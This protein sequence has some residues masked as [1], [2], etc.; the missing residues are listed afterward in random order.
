[1]AERGRGGRDNK[2]YAHCSIE[3]VGKFS[4]LIL[5]RHDSHMNTKPTDQQCQVCDE[6]FNTSIEVLKHDA[7]SQ[8]DSFIKISN[9]VVNLKD[10]EP[11]DR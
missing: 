8:K 6:G 3:L 2:K 9:G 1:M 10:N 7:N 11:K 4:T 5:L